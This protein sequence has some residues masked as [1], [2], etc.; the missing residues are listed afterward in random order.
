MD[1]RRGFNSTSRSRRPYT[2]AS[3]P[4]GGWTGDGDV[5]TRHDMPNVHFETRSCVCLWSRDRPTAFTRSAHVLK[6]ETWV[7][8]LPC[9]W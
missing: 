4:G 1:A 8:A 6:T 5:N 3:L 9:G 7:G 2:S